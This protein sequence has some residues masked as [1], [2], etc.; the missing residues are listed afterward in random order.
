MIRC[1]QVSV[2]AARWPD[3]MLSRFT[4]LGSGGEMTPGQVRDYLLGLKAN[5]Y[6]VLPC[7]KHICDEKGEC[8]GKK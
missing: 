1:M 7:G 5:G 4:W 2:D 3:E 6:K 8:T